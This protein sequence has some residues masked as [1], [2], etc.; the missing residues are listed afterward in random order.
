MRADEM[1]VTTDAREETTVKTDV[2]TTETAAV[3]IVLSERTQ[4]RA[5]NNVDA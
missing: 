2:P 5:I 4:R 3:R 1:T